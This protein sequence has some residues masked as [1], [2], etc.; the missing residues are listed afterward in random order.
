MIISIMNWI[1][2][3]DTS[4]PLAVAFIPSLSAHSLP[5]CIRKPSLVHLPII[6][7]VSGAKG[8]I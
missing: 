5:G 7:S 6:E 8:S 1:F 3:A 4:H 2:K